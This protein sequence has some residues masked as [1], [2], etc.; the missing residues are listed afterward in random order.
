MYLRGDEYADDLALL[1]PYHRYLD[2]T[3]RRETAA[4][5]ASLFFY[6][7]DVETEPHHWAPEPDGPSIFDSILFDGGALT[8]LAARTRV[9][10]VV[11]RVG[12][13]S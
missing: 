7:Y 3:C 11:A 10:S 13:A 1:F 8:P 12:P 2:T 6:S 4:T 9:P 5:A